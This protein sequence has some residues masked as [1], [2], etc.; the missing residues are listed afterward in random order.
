MIS[1]PGI[2]LRKALSGSRNT[3]ALIWVPRRC[4]R[5]PLEHAARAAAQLQAASAQSFRVLARKGPAHA[6]AEIDATMICTRQAGRGRKKPG[7][8]EWKEMRLSAAQAQ[9][10]TQTF[11]A[12]G[13]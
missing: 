5:R 3:T 2:P 9:D 13:F 6:V 11:Y 1:V 12:A 4:G 7:P 8:R 10:S